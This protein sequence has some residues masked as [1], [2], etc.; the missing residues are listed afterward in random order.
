MEPVK[1][2]IVGCGVIGKKHIQLALTIPT[3][4]VVA[5]AD[6][7]EE[8]V[9]D[10]A[11]K[12]GVPKAYTTAEALI[13]DPEV[14]A[15][16]LAMPTHVRTPLGVYTLKKGKH[17]L[18]E[19]PVAMNSGEVKQLMA[20]QPKGVVAA[21]CSCR[22]TSLPSAQTAAK[23]IA[24]GALGKLRVLRIRHLGAAGEAPKNP[25][26]VW[27][28]R[29]DLNGGGILMNWGCY[30]LDYIMGVTGWRVR[31]RCVLAR[32][33]QV[34]PHL[35]SRAA[36]GS[37]AE[38]HVAAVVL[39]DDD[40]ALTYERGEFMA[41]ANESAWQVTGEKGSLRMPLVPRPGVEV[42]HDQSSDDVGVTSQSI[43]AGSENWENVHT[44]PIAD[45]AA[46]IQEE[47][48]PMTSLARALIVQQV[49]DAIYDSAASGKCV[50]IK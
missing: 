26:P 29:K 6:L 38:T 23:L 31:P 19:K 27:R 36:P 7:R 17:L 50:E 30:D 20:A 48:E 11:K 44:G 39:C 41:A 40:I 1:V 25:A 32:T 5:I 42:M 35:A 47:R 14:Q 28:L 12:H 3:V 16:V 33:W 8:L 9:R 43:W 18:T 2:G 22:H 4:E 21:C 34:A 13:D 15:V 37:D 10:L 49:A 45:F 24:S 46:A